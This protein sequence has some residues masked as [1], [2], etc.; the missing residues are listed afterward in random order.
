[1][2][3]FVV[4]PP[5]PGLRAKNPL[6]ASGSTRKMKSIQRA[7]KE[8]KGNEYYSSDDESCDPDDS[9]GAEVKGDSDYKED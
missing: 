5:K 4:S 2:Q 3:P 6:D 7:F 8:T 1:M 9:S